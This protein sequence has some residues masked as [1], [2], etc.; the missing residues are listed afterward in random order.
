MD[1]T[2][3]LLHD[4]YSAKIPQFLVSQYL[5]PVE[6][7]IR[8]CSLVLLFNQALENDVNI[9]LTILHVPDTITCGSTKH[10]THI[11]GTVSSKTEKKSFH[12]NELN[13][14]AL[15]VFPIDMFYLQYD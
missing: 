3:K 13:I 15:I 8:Q 11:L 1:E 10:L 4:S 6:N 2:I 14:S 9:F 5:E 7:N 12:I